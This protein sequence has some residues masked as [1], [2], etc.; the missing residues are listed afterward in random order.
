MKK[1]L[2][3][4]LMFVMAFSLVSCKDDDNDVDNGG[5]N[6]QQQQQTPATED[7]LVADQFANLVAGKEVYLTTVG[8][9]DIDTVQNI[10]S[11]V[12]ETKVG[13]N[14]ES[15][16][17]NVH[18]ENVL[19]VADVADGSVVFLVTGSSTKGLGAAGTNITA[20]NTR[21]QAFADAAKANK[22]TLVVLHV[23]GAQRRG[24]QADPIINKVVPAAKLVMVVNTG[25]ADG[26]F[27]NLS[28]AN[29]VAFNSYT[30]SSKMVD[31]FKKIFGIA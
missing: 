11:R 10:I 16:E 30:K 24:E 4:A 18:V 13:F 5:N 7:L 26:L 15:K 21:A 22:I 25:N 1:L 14:D 20:E 8:Q 6:N 3:L 2:T 23:G 29:G 27:T 28:S 17:I 31:S 19:N 12:D 9:S